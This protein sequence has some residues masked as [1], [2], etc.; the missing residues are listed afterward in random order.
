MTLRQIKKHINISKNKLIE[1]LYE[2]VDDKV[3]INQQRKKIYKS[4]TYSFEP[5]QLE[6]YSDG[7]YVAYYEYYNGLMTMRT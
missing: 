5:F 1:M 6:N 4:E 3:Y 2:Y 7:T